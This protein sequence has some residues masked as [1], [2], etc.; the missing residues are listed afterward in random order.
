M[1]SFPD[2]K[3]QRQISTEGGVSP[4]LARSGPLEE[5]YCQHGD[6]VMAVELTLTTRPIVVG[7][8]RELFTGPY[9]PGFDVTRDGQHFLMLLPNERLAAT[10]VNVV[11]NWFEDLKRRSRRRQGSSPH[12]ARHRLSPRFR[13][14]PRRAQQRRLGVRVPFG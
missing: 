1:G 4:R 2:G 7:K 6:Q 8:T 3:Q 11:L 5:L 10:Q 9:E 12:S 13:R 14:N